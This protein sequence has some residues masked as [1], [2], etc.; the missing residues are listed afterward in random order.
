V[1]ADGHIRDVLME[2]LMRAMPARRLRSLLLVAGLLLLTFPLMVCSGGR[3]PALSQR[4]QVF[5]KLEYQP[6]PATVTK[7]S[8]QTVAALHPKAREIG[9]DALKA[10]GNAYDA[11]VATTFAEYVLSEGGSSIGGPLGVLAYDAATKK[12][13]YLDADFSTPL[14][15]A[16]AKYDP[17]RPG[18]GALVPGAPAGLEEL[19]KRGKLG[20]ARLIQ[21][22]VDL[23]QSGFAVS[24]L[25]AGILDS[26]ADRLRKSE[27][28]RSTL[29]QPDGAPLK[30]GSRLVQPEFAAFL[31]K[32]QATGSRYMYEGEW[33]D[34]FLRTVRGAGGILTEADLR[35]YR[36]RWVEPW[37]I[38]YRDYTILSSSG[39]SYGGPWSLMVMKTLEHANLSSMP[40]PS[41]S[42]ETLEMMIRAAREVWTTPWL[43]DCLAISGSNP[44]C[45]L[46]RASEV[47]SHLDRDGGQIWSRVAARMPSVAKYQTRSHSYH[48]IATDRQGN[49]VCGTHTIEGSAWGDALFVDG[50]PLTNAGIIAWGTRAGERRL[51]PL[52]MHFAFRDG[53]IAFAQGA[54]SNSVLEASVQFLVN[55]ID[56]RLSPGEALSRPRFGTFPPKGDTF[57]VDWST[58][59]LSPDIGEDIVRTLK[60]RKINVRNT[61]IVDTGL[62][63]LLSFKT[64]VQNLAEQT[65]VETV[66]TPLPYVNDPFGSS[67]AP[68]KLRR[69]AAGAR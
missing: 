48:V 56:Y 33:G 38:T 3:E 59:W 12:A 34:R 69:K 27:Y 25:F 37:K 21:P 43:F 13:E 39:R 52:T 17:K 44:V 11:F 1:V 67:S 47:Q 55:M 24:N 63:T 46:D 61:G 50:V 64:G 7:D 40:H 62:G 49:V 57:D 42:A 53:R 16:N 23:A 5:S 32:L 30:A 45:T 10:G 18:T 60:D 36:A 58:N 20:W 26:E 68:P 66:N 4:E 2:V 19:A 41:T 9:I 28:A 15:L 22:A 8:E 14:D 65:V 31:T 51:S 54:I 6:E 29:F 35:S